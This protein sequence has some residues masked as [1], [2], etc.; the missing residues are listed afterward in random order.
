MMAVLVPF[1]PA[2]V[3]CCTKV[4]VPLRMTASFS[5]SDRLSVS[6]SSGLHAWSTIVVEF[7]MAKVVRVPSIGD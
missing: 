6:P 1:T 3:S 4:H 2:F 5:F 7:E